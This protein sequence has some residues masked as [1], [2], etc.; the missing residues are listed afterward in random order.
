M[1][2][3]ASGPAPT[4]VDRRG[5]PPSSSPAGLTR[6]EVDERVRAGLVNASD[7]RTS[8]TIGEIVRANVLTPF[9]FLLGSLGVV[10]ILT[11]RLGDALFLLVLVI[12]S[13]IG[14]VQEVLAKRKLDRLAL[15]HAPTTRVVRDGAAVEVPSH[16][17]V[18][19]DLIELRTGDQVPADGDVIDT[20]GLEIDES[21]LTGE[22]DPVDKSVGDP[23]LSG[24]I[25]V[26]GSGRFHAEAVGADAYARRVAAEAKVFTRTRSELM[27]GI[28]LLL[29]YITWVIIGVTPLLLWSQWRT[30]TTDDWRDPV[31]GSVAALV[32]M[33]PEGLV[34]LTSV[35]FLL[36]AVAL[37]RQ[38]VLV[39]QLPAVE[40]LARV[41]VVCTDKTGTL[42]EGDIVFE[43]ARGGR[44]PRRRRG[45]ARRARRRPVAQRHVQGGR[46]RRSRHRTAGSATTPCRSRR[47]ASGARRASRARAPGCSA[48]P[49]CCSTTTIRC[50]RRSPT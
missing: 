34:L 35:A 8:R 23:V 20:S 9:N 25:V 22:S 33:V 17:V 32:G 24:T 47:P 3:P 4:A 42:T 41:D 21:N 38:Q 39:Q 13:L 11:G 14:I 44:R 30:R 31:V 29:K 16:E 15:L 12:N 28:N 43:R 7:E 6:A 50:A 1:T 46:R 48:R 18:L 10:V 19:D 26:A 45:G 27:E 2:P 37:T 40:G 36:A 49:T 5:V